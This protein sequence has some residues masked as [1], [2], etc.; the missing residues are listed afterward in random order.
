[1]AGTAL[2]VIGAIA[3]TGAMVAVAIEGQAPPPVSD[4]VSS[5]YAASP[6]LTAAAE[7]PL[8][9]IVGDSY[10]GPLVQDG[11]K[12]PNWADTVKANLTSS[13]KRVDIKV[14]SSG[15]SGYVTAGPTATV[16]GQ[17]VTG[18]V[19]P[20]TDVIVFF[21][22]RN[23]AGQAPAAVGS[24]AAEAFKSAKAIA[25]AARLVV[26]GPAWTEPVTPASILA[27]RDSLKRAAS[28]HQATFVD[29]LADAW[30]QGASFSG[31]G[32]DRIHPNK[33]GHEYMASLI[34]P[35]IAASL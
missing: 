13:G 33:A 5:Y 28:D 27:I 16:F 7:V 9:S 18:T 21:G 10:S 4:Q 3:I 32:S 11:A 26:I 30:F 6:T 31:I 8:V 17:D 34:Q 1:M 22:S 20:Q 29:P 19:T 24:A 14:N 12:L 2:G 25:P 35:V 23:D 15:G